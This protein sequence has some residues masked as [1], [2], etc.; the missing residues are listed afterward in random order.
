MPGSSVDLDSPF[1]SNCDCNVIFVIFRDESEKAVD[2]PVF[3]GAWHWSRSTET[4]YA[5]LMAA[6]DD[7]DA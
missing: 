3:E 7:P 6:H 1:N 2:A 4:T 5:Y